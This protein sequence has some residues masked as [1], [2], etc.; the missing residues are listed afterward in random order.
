MSLEISR[1]REKV[2]KQNEIAKMEIY[3]NVLKADGEQLMVVHIG[4]SNAELE[5][6]NYQKEIRPLLYKQLHLIDGDVASILN[7]IDNIIA[8]CNFNEEITKEQNNYL[9]K[10]YME[11][12]EKIKVHVDNF[13]KNLYD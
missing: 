5:I 3:N 2:K 1:E 9:S 7:S 8:E 12:I 6:E 4:G 10:I 11:L 13:R